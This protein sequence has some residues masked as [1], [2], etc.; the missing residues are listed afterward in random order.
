MQDIRENS[1]DIFEKETEPN[2]CNGSVFL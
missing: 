2:I 1:Q